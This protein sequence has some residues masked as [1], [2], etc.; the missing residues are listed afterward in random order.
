MGKII[1][2]L[3]GARSG[4][5]SHVLRLAEA[6]GK[7][8]TFL[9]TAQALD[10]EMSARIKSHKEERPLHWRT[11]E[12]PLGI[13]PYVEGIQSEIVILDCVTLLISNLLMQFLKDDFVDEA[14]FVRSTDREVDELLTAIQRSDQE[15]LIVS[16]E[17]GLG[18]VPPYPSGRIYRDAL[19]RANQRIASH[20]NEVY[21]L[22]A[23]IPVPI[24]QFRVWSPHQI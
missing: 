17:V 19:G 20:A 4:K 13:A 7:S 11:V 22:V 18:L 15:W 1:F 5:S 16:N 2:V 14:S 24:H 10:D 21:W 8:V 9:A 23:G 3:G 12:I 6:T